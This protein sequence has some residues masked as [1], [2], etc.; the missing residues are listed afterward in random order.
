[1]TQR[2]VGAAESGNDLRLVTEAATPLKTPK[3][4]PRQTPREFA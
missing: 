2:N 1:M 4:Y 3:A